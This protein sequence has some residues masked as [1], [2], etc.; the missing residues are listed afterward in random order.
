[1]AVLRTT[2]GLKHVFRHPAW[3][4]RIS[5]MVPC[6]FLVFCAGMGRV[7]GQEFSE[8]EVKAAILLKITTFIS[9][10]QAEMEEDQNE[11][12]ETPAF[13]LG[14]LGD[15]PFGAIL[16]SVFIGKKIDDKPV[17]ILRAADVDA[18]SECAL[19][20]FSSS[21]KARISDT[22]EAFKEKPVLTVADWN[23]FCQEGGMINLVLRDKKISFE[24]NAKEVKKSG[25]KAS[26]QLLKLSTIVKT[27]EKD[28]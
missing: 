23:G 24:I 6:F 17:K 14:V 28:N 13:C 20:F 19:I 27:K 10:P 22:L 1:M 5:A 16:D 9:W 21:K 25:L 4:G 26:S 11:E 12:A 2:F 18:L 8:Y 15:D 3:D 7:W